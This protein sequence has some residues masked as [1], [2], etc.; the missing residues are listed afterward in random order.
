LVPTEVENT[1]DD[2]PR[3][4]MIAKFYCGWATGVTQAREELTEIA[5]A[6]E[7]EIGDRTDRGYGPPL[8]PTAP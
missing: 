5:E 1:D 4:D 8:P 6:K 7:G 3:V 2:D